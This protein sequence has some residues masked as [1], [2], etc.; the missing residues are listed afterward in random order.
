M[1]QWLSGSRYSCFTGAHGAAAS[2]SIERSSAGAHGAVV[3]SEYTEQ[4][5][6]CVELQCLFPERGCSVLHV[7]HQ[8]CSL[9]S[10]EAV[11]SCA[12][13]E[14]LYVLP[15]THCSTDI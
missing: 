4:L 8:K 7:L 5:C 3:F 14:Q 9:C 11:A 6:R 1:Q 13:F 10:G 15:E 12:L 2:R